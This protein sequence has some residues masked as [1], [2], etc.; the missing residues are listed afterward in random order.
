MALLVPP[1]DPEMVA[2]PEAFILA[3]ARECF[4]ASRDPALWPLLSQGE[5]DEWC[6]AAIMRPEAA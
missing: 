1:L 5:R 2:D 6:R 3:Q 4:E